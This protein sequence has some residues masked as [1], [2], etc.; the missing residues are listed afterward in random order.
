MSIA[1]RFDNLV[2]LHREIY[3]SSD[4]QI[5]SYLRTRLKMIKK[6][7]NKLGIKPIVTI[8]PYMCKTCGST[9]NEWTKEGKCFHCYTENVKSLN[10]V[11]KK[12]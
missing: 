5:R 9:S 2:Y 4:E 11:I 12:P 10:I 8:M 3:N 6:K 1:K 7:N